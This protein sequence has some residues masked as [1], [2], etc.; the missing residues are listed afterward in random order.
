[1]RRASIEAR[2]VA[3]C[4]FF[5]GSVG[6][7]GGIS[8]TEQARRSAVVARV[9][10]RTITAGE[11]ED[12]MAVVPRFQLVT[13]GDT[14]DAIRRKFLNEVVLPEVLLSAGAEDAHIDRMPPTVHMLARARSSATLRAFRAQLGR[15]A[16]IPMADVRRYYDENRAKFDSP[17]RIQIWRI[18]CKSREEA[19]AVLDAA[20]KDSTPENFTK[21]ARDHSQDKATNL[22]GGNLGF[23]GPDGASN[24]AGLKADPALV[25]AAAAVKDGEII[26]QPVAEGAGFSVVWR[27][28]TVGASHRTV[29]E[30]KEQ[31]RDTLWKQKNEEGSQKLIK[32][33]R[34][35]DLHELNESLV[36]T[37]EINPTDGE[38]V[39]RR[40][41]GQ[42][43]PIN[44]I[45]SPKPTASK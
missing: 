12:R 1:M 14:P 30:A 39:Q 32:D 22:R 43:P 6:A 19:V 26:P 42:V 9:G 3:I 34:A 2:L 4:L 21:L 23:L 28:G 40:R 15:A 31:I 18:L 45:G 10:S 36:D 17:E 27:R 41:P 11:L 38:I 20:K 24:E 33:L 44:Q 29:E 8:A 37:I 25:K 16:D 7:D 35:R 13:F 5:V